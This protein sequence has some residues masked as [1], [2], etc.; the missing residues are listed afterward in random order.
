MGVE[1]AIVGQRG[2]LGFE[3]RSNTPRRTAVIVCRIRADADLSFAKAKLIR[4]G[5]IVAVGIVIIVV[6]VI[7]TLRVAFC[8]IR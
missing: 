8:K 3:H 4:C 2:G 7:F 5:V 1:G 6:V